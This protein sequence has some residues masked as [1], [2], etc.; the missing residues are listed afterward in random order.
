M[1]RGTPMC[2]R[3]KQELAAVTDH[4]AFQRAL[5]TIYQSSKS[6]VFELLTD[7]VIFGASI[8]Y[9]LTVAAVLVLRHSNPHLER[10]Y[11][12]WG[13]PWVP[14]TFVVVYIWFLGTLLVD[15]PLESGIGIA[16]IATGFPAYYFWHKRRHSTDRPIVD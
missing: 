10:P 5:E 15:N 2:Y 9:V 4:L 11:Q 3:E 16:L 14:L 6:H 12:T 13:Y 7:L 1:F 8:F